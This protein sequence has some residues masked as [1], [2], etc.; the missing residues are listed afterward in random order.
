MAKTAE[1]PSVL[2]FEKKLA[3][4][5]GRLYGCQWQ[6]RHATATPLKLIEKSVRGTIS[7]RL[8]AALQK[9]PAKLDAEVQK[10]NLQT[11][12]VCMLPGNADTLQVQFSLKVLSRIDEPSACN[13]DDFA[14]TYRAAVAD[15]IDREG[16]REVAYR[17]AT[18]L[19][20][21]RFLWRNRVGAEAVEVVVT[22]GF[23]KESEPLTFDALAIGLGSPTHDDAAALGDMIA[24]ALCGKRDYLFLNV[25]ASVRVG[26]GQEVFP[27]QELITG[28]AEKSKHLYQVDG[29]AAMHSQK[30]GNAIRTIDTWYDEDADSP[31]AIEVYGSV[32][33]RGKAY[34]PPK[35]KNDFYTLFD[36]FAVGAS[37]PLIDQHYVM[38]MLV[39]GG[40]FG[41]S[42]N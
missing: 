6:D 27:S 10:A 15:Y 14:Q 25:T 28:D 26:A 12:D 9:D 29:V 22:E 40:V 2:A 1:I 42:S 4:S 11:V 21:G 30:L 5:D 24:A 19:A 17:Y 35:S 16:F 3:P 33:S 34:R 32:T 31:I 37:L 36:K 8:K 23:Q 41:S 39:R 38:A 20:N 13:G 7:N 18:N